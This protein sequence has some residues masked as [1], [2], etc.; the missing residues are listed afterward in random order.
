M[1]ERLT[2]SNV[3]KVA[4]TAVCFGFFNT[5]I[6]TMMVCDGESMLPTVKSVGELAIVDI[7]SQKFLEEKY[8]RGDVVIAQLEPGKSK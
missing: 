7:F 6:A 4:Y 1:L 3:Y 8:Q 2:R 5:N